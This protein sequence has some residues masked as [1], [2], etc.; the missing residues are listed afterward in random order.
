MAAY[1]I[2]SFDITDAEAYEDYP[3][4]VIP[5][6]EKHGAE[7]LVADYEARAIEGEARGVNVVLRFETEEAAMNW[8]NDPEYA[9]V[10]QLR[11]D[12]TANTTV[13]LAKE[14]VM[15]AE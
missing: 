2:V 10:K 11:F 14:F 13:H 15:P 7:I 12:T 9:P 5:L 1:F 8:Y 4:G 6:L 3:P